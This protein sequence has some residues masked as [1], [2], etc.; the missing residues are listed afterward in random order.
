MKIATGEEVL[1]RHTATTDYSNIPTIYATFQNMT[2]VRHYPWYWHST[3]QI[4]FLLVGTFT[5]KG[6]QYLLGKI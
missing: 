1:S 3:R 6:S 5:L 2:G 4:G